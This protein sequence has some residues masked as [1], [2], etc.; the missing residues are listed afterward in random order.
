VTLR[1]T[2]RAWLRAGATRNRVGALVPD[3]RSEDERRYEE[4]QSRAKEEGR[5]KFWV[6]WTFRW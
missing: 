5:P 2:L 1:D 3:A 6:K 4:A